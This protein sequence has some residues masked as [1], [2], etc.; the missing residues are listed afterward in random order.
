[1]VNWKKVN[2]NKVSESFDI[3]RQLCMLTLQELER[4]SVDIFLVKKE[5]ERSLVSS[6]VNSNTVGLTIAYMYNKYIYDMNSR[7]NGR[8]Y[9][10]GFIIMC[11]KFCNQWTAT[12]HVDRVII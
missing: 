1:M 6:K 10:K 3:R 5:D 2:V 9:I 4:L 12:R 8:L 7:Y 11:T